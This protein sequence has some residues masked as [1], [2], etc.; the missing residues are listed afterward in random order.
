ML[1]RKDKTFETTHPLSTHVNKLMTKTVVKNMYRQ[2][3]TTQTD[4]CVEEEEL[5]K[6]FLDIFKLKNIKALKPAREMNEPLQ[7]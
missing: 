3:N 2:F 7:L 5:T 6:N 1:L 4:K